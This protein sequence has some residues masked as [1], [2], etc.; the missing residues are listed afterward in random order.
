MN[1]G[2]NGTFNILDWSAY[3]QWEKT[4]YIVTEQ[5]ATMKDYYGNFH[6]DV[7]DVHRSRHIE[8]D[9]LSYAVATRDIKAGE[10]IFSNY[11]FYASNEKE[12]KEDVMDLR[13]WCSGEDVGSITQ[14][15][16]SK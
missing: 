9:T 14:I 15:E 6:D 3:L 13:R 12:W 4:G 2:C 10:E 11:V 8:S 16:Q 5:N 1:H 7:F